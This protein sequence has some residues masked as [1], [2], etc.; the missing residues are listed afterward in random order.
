MIDVPRTVYAHI[1]ADDRVLYV[2]A[3]CRLS[4][5]TAHHRGQSPWWPLVER[6]EV[7][8]AD[9]PGR[10]AKDLERRLIETLNP[11]HNT[12]FTAAWRDAIKARRAA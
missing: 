12:V 4:A 11:P 8:A 2:G 5:R 9:L 3:S 6:V 10:D 1:A 7:V